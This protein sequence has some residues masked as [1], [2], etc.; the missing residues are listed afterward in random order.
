MKTINMEGRDKG[1]IKIDQKLALDFQEGVMQTA[2]VVVS[3]A[4]GLIGVWG[5]LSL[6]GGIAMGGGIMEMARGWLSSIAGM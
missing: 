1:T 6:F 5:V 2:L 4:A 3:L